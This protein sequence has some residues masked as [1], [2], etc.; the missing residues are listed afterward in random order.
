[1][2]SIPHFI[3]VGDRKQT[4]FWFF[5][6]CFRFFKQE[7]MIKFC[8]GFKMT[9]QVALGSSL[10]NKLGKEYLGL[11]RPVRRLQPSLGVNGMIE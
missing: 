7:G 8:L 5:V 1:M 10:P 4:I 9:S 2:K 6:L 11:V 3:H